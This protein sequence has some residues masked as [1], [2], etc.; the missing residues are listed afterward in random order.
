MGYPDWVIFQRTESGRAEIR[1]KQ[2]GLTQS[3]RLVLI[4]AD[5]VSTYAG[6]RLK[7]KSLTRERFDRAVRKLAGK[8]LLYEVMF[9]EEGQQPDTVDPELMDKFLRQEDDDP[10]SILSFDPDEEHGDASLEP[11]HAMQHPAL[12]TGQP[13]G[14]GYHPASKV[15]PADTQ[16]G[17]AAAEAVHRH[18]GETGLEHRL[19]DITLEPDRR[20]VMVNTAVVA[21]TVAVFPEPRQLPTKKMARRN[22]PDLLSRLRLN[23]SYILFFAGISLICAPFLAKFMQWLMM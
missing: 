6:L 17:H 12:A 9:P 7:L 10:V 20:A 16:P 22:A 15:A 5:G 19:S 23:S 1:D 3:E 11:M 18:A 4:I 2:R 13:H 8:E 21:K 14:P